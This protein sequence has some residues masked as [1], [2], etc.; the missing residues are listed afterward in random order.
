MTDKGTFNKVGLYRTVC[1][2]NLMLTVS[3]N[4]SLTSELVQDRETSSHGKFI[5]CF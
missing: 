3:S 5:L 1:I 2:H 4:E